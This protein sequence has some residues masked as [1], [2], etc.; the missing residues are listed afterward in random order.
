[1]GEAILDFAEPGAQ[2]GLR[3]MNADAP[4]P[5]ILPDNVVFTCQ[6][7]GACCRSDWLIGVDEAAHARLEDVRWADVDPA[8]PAGPKFVP[9]PF[10]LPSGER[11]TLARKPGGACVFLTEDSRCAIHR[12]LGGRAKPQVCREFPYQ[13]VETPD[14]VSV[15]VSFACTAVRAHAGRRLGE[16]QDEIQE[17]L[18]G[19]R[20]VRRLPDPLVLY[21]S[22]E[23]GWPEYREIEAAL[24]TLL[25]EAPG[26]VPVAL[27]AGSA[28]VSLCVGLTQ[29]E[30]RAHREGRAP[31]ETLAGGLAKLR[32]SGYQRLVEIAAG[33]RY[34]RRPSLT[35][36]APLWTWLGFSRRRTSRVGLVL[37]LYANYFRFRRGRGRLPDVI[38]GG[39]P[40][41]LEAAQRVR[42]DPR[43]S[44]VDS[45]LREYWSHVIFRKTL[46]PMH[47]VFR[48]YQTMLTLYALMKWAAKLEALRRGRT[49]VEPADVREA[50]RLVEQR[51]VLHARFADV[52]A[53]SPTLTLMADRVYRDPAFVRA[54][55]LEP[56]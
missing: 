34:P 45:F 22:I 52:F 11:V 48:G 15:G 23:L 9:L 50:V 37:A 18:A 30:A 27:L 28:L 21:G 55:V 4:R 6:N 14:G 54:A 44:E 25:A 51:V 35:F 33:A 41:D 8:L 26:G 1:V 5:L 10:A 31:E 20:R 3:A 12:G 56:A 46:T 38:A 49:G 40:F 29:V 42:F 24:L 39:A 36:L 7:S 2:T 19:S 47:G 13:F 32:A 53:L 43:H 17:V 16:Q